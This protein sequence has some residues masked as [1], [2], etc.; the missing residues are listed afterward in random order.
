[1]V[2]MKADIVN[3]IRRLPKPSNSSEALQPLFEAVS[4][5][6]HAVDDLFGEAVVEHGRVAIDI[7][8][9]REPEH[10]EI[11]VRDNGIGFDDERFEAFRTTD[12]DF[13]IKKGG[14]GV[15]RLLWLDA[16]E[17]IKVDSIFEK[18][19]ALLRRS[20][21]FRLTAEEQ[22]DSKAL[23]DVT[24]QVVAPGTNIRFEGLRG[25]A[26]SSLFPSYAKTLINHFGSHF[27]ANFI[28]GRAPLIELTIDGEITRFPDGITDLLFEKR[29]PSTIKTEE[30]GNLELSSFIFRKQASSDFSGLH[31]LHFIAASRTVMSRKIDGLLGLGRFGEDN[32]LVYHGCVEGDFL[33]ERVNQERTHFNFSED[34]AE[35]ISKICA[36]TARENALHEEV[37]D[38]DTDRLETMRAFLNDYPSFQ[39][40]PPQEL[41]DSTPK[42]A[43]K[44]EHFAQALI[45]R[46]IR[47][48]NE[49][50]VQVQMVVDTLSSEAEV[51]KDFAEAVR[52]AADEV[53]AEEQRQLTEY[54]LRRKMVLDVLDVLVRRVR[55]TNSGD[56][57]HHLESTLHQ[58]ICPMKLRGDD[59]SRVQASDH[60]LWIID[61]RLAFATYFASDVPF[62]QIVAE[63]Q[64]TERP[65]ILIFDKL[66]G[67]GLEEDEP[68]SRVLLVEFKKPGRKDYEDKYTPQNQI[69]RY[70]AELSGGNIENYRGERIRIAPDCVF[71]CYVVAD[72]VGSLD[73]YTSTWQTTANGRGRWTPLSGKYRGS[74]ELI[75]WKDLVKDARARNRAFIDAAGVKK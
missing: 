55:E 47:R 9:L 2:G 13:R 70:L 68:L 72:I 38:F 54:V 75:E 56:R 60:D 65:D 16:F 31:Q 25:N 63:T 19:G 22:I 58:F 14:K 3:R 64:N 29:N 21:T 52:S 28:L 48:D 57:T 32:D 11:A 26:Y 12:T 18:N 43:T 61:E 4:N 10:I 30:F 73:V 7:N 46:R 53:R 23:M 1:M 34:V 42:N 71:Y 62:S 33:D 69:A 17:R 51:P 24:G 36:T 67:L 66:H 8:T 37:E 15:G 6:I 45:P 41:L 39:F 50:R 74:I 27:L 20:F 49:R 35:E 59:P 44:P 40:A 5:A